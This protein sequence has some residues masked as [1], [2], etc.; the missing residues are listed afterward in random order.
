[1][2]QLSEAKKAQINELK[3]SLELIPKNQR[4]AVLAKGMEIAQQ[5]QKVARLKLEREDL[6]K[7]L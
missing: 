7:S 2:P 1:M 4:K 5:R 3:R 6:L